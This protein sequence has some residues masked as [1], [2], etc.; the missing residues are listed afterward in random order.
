MCFHLHADMIDPKTL[1]QVV[2]F[3]SGW[4]VVY[5]LIFVFFYW[6]FY[7]HFKCYPLYRS[8]H[9]GNPHHNPPLPVSMRVLC[10]SP[11]YPLYLV[12]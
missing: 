1:L 3:F 5:F 11:T 6:T 9:L 10:P 2:I 4:E 12:T 8:A 7:L